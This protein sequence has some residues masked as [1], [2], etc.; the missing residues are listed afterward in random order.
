M[1]YTESSMSGWVLYSA[2]MTA[3]VAVYNIIFGLV[4]LLNDSWV[5]LTTE[6]TLLFNTATLGWILLILGFV[7]F[8]VT[9][10]ILR[11][12][13]W[14]RLLGLMWASF[15]AVAQMALISV[16]PL[17]SLVIIALCVLVV[18]GLAMHGEEIG[19]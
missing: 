10:G 14:A 19:P 12:A 16:Y 15:I 3:V 4:L 1:T 8:A 17:W 2:A 18:Y 9:F 6:E 7:Q 13:A 5:F 11:G